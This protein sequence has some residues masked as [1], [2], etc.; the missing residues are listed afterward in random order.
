MKQGNKNIM[1]ADLKFREALRKAANE[2]VRKYPKERAKLTDRE[3]TRMLTNTE[4]FQISLKEL[5]TK[6]R[7]RR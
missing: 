3:L 2:R 1:R 7:K 6:P 5:K 4:G